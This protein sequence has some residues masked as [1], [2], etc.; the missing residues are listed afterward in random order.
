MRAF[1]HARRALLP[2]GLICLSAPAAAQQ[3]DWADFTAW[4]AN[5][6]TGTAAY[7]GGGN[8]SINVASSY[9]QNGVAQS[10]VFAA[11]FPA[12]DPAP[13]LSL[14][15][16]GAP[17]TAS[18][19]NG[20]VGAASSVRIRGQL[21]GG[22]F[23]VGAITQTLT[24]NFT[25]TAPGHADGDTLVGLSAVY[26]NTP[27][28]PPTFPGSRANSRF[29]I[30]AVRCDG[31]PETDF[32]NWS[33]IAAPAGFT[34]T[35]GSGIVFSTAVSGSATAAGYVVSVGT[36]SPYNGNQDSVPTLVR[37]GPDSCYNGIAITRAIDSVAGNT[38]NV[39]NAGDFEYFKLFAAR[40]VNTDFDDAPASYGTASHAYATGE[41]RLGSGVTY[42]PATYDSPTASADTDDAFTTLP[43]VAAQAGNPYSLTV[44]LSEVDAAARLCGYIDFNR[45]GDFSDAGE[46]ACANVATAATAA[47]LTW[48]VPAGTAYVAGNSY[49]RFRLAS[50]AAEAQSPTGTANSGEVEDYVVALLPRARLNKT[51]SPTGDPGVF[52]LSIGPTVLPAGTATANNQGNG[53]TTGFA[54]VGLNT[55]VTVSETAGTGTDL[56]AYKSA[57]ACVNRAGGVVLANGVGGSGGFTTMAS[58]S[59]SANA[60]PATAANSDDTEVV[61]TLTNTRLSTDL[62]ISKTNTPANGAD[63]QPAD[64]LVSGTATT[65]SLRAVDAGPDAS[66]NAVVTDTP[67]AGITCPGALGNTTVTCA[68]TSSPVG[69]TTCPGASALTTAN[70]FGAGIAIPSLGVSPVPATPNNFVVLTFTCTVN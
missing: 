2:A 52:D 58:A 7:P 17:F 12:A 27:A 31:T 60:T 21:P 19:P 68:A 20:T 46:Q 57:R 23:A 64:T 15:A 51:L 42:D 8:L 26:P 39:S 16:A 25:T 43:A 18:I 30:T 55:A 4:T 29:T 5:S 70:L 59:T 41:L 40:V 13:E 1:A 35:D 14:F 10:Y 65:Y 34:A 9:T 50:V 61:C 3:L 48:I 69:A 67:G 53:G 24:L 22:V 47:T 44:P 36:R 62:S 6:A 66:T 56:A 63:D 38:N 32:S 37:P 54:A 45:D 11:G 49:A 28:A 33:S